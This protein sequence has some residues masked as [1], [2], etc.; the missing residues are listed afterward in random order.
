MR[1]TVLHATLLLPSIYFNTNRTEDIKS[2]K[3]V[4]DTREGN[5][6]FDHRSGSEDQQT[7]SSHFSSSLKWRQHLQGPNSVLTRQGLLKQPVC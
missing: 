4:L 7:K 1:T 3:K 2:L 5:S 6:V